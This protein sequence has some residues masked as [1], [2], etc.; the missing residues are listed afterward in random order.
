MFAK[1]LLYEGEKMP[2]SLFF[3]ATC[4]DIW[5][6]YKELY[7]F[8]V[9]NLMSLETIKTKV[10]WRWGAG[11]ASLKRA[12]YSQKNVANVISVN[13]IKCENLQKKKKREKKKGKFGTRR[14]EE[15]RFLSSCVDVTMQTQQFLCWW[16]QFGLCEPK[17]HKIKVLG[18]SIRAADVTTSIS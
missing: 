12:C 7:L 15:Q 6:T 5:L 4:I 17:R 18:L 8:N 14:F 11:K 13:G 9:H 10:G 1:R 2:F 3:K 16:E